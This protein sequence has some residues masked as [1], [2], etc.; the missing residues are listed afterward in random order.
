MCIVN[1]WI[2]YKLSLKKSI[3]Q[4]QFIRDVY[5]HFKKLNDSKIK[6][7]AQVRTFIKLKK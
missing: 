7:Q 1:S 3:S 2:L 6:T 4:F 5:N